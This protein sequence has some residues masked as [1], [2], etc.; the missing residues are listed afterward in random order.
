[1]ADF[2]ISQRSLVASVSSVDDVLPIWQTAA[3]HTA[4][5]SQILASHGGGVQAGPLVTVTGIKI[6]APVTSLRTSGYTIP[7]DGGGAL[8]KRVSV[9]PVHSGKFQS[10][11]GAWWELIPEN[12][13]IDPKQLGAVAN[14]VADDSTALINAEAT[15]FALGVILFFSTGVYTYSGTMNCRVSIMSVNGTLKQI[16]P[17]PGPAY[18]F[19]EPTLHFGPGTNMFIDGLTVESPTFRG[20]I[21]DTITGLIINRVTV[22][23]AALTGIAQMSCTNVLISNCYVNYTMYP[24]HTYPML[25]G[26]G[27]SFYN[28]ISSHVTY[29]NCHAYDFTRIGFTSEGT[30]WQDIYSS[31]DVNYLYCTAEYAHD[32]I[33]YSTTEYN[34]GLWLEH[35]RSGSVIGCTFKNIDS[36]VGQLSGNLTRGIILAGNYSDNIYNFEVK[37]CTVLANGTLGIGL[38][39][40]LDSFNGRIFVENIKFD[41]C[42]SPVGISGNADS[43]T[44]KNIVINAMTADLTS[45]AHG[46][47]VFSTAANQTINNLI[48]DN[49]RFSNCTGTCY[50]FNLSPGF[51]GNIRIVNTISPYGGTFGNQISSLTIDNCD[52]T[53]LTDGHDF[54]ADNIFVSNSTIRLTT[55]GVQALF[56]AG[57]GPSTMQFSNTRFTTTGLAFNSTFG[58]PSRTTRFDNCVFDKVSF[59]FDLTGV[60]SN[61]FS[62][63]DF[64]NPLSSALAVGFGTY[65]RH[66]LIVSN[67]RFVGTAVGNTPMHNMNTSLPTYTV[68]SNNTYNTTSLV[69]W[70]TGV[71]NISPVQTL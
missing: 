52:L 63:C 71:T 51:F 35:T 17:T 13:R 57:T 42:K 47:A 21:A 59:I 44:L 54:I 16:R 55:G 48:L 7:G 11:D 69:D 53:N 19:F 37:D 31:S 23:H 33:T 8:Y 46:S 62:N 67:C 39:L 70:A 26:A 27:D 12:V 25:G 29:F 45:Y 14:G 9:A 15:A 50:L 61:K 28:H 38:S 2:N 56:T 4:N 20:I 40:G 65:T 18:D 5:A 34:A 43:V 22:N 58:G 1:M 24:V 3:Q 64:I 30:G 6:S 32:C 41:N 68:L 10:N 60:N 36:G 66:E 49:F